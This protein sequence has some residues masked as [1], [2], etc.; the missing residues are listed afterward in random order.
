MSVP[1]NLPT[2]HRECLNLAVI[3]LDQAE[4]L[5]N[6]NGTGDAVLANSVA[7]IGQ[8]WAAVA[9]AM[10]EAERQVTYVT[11]ELESVSMELGQ[12][13][14]VK[15]DLSQFKPG[16]SVPALTP[17]GQEGWDHQHTSFCRHNWV[18]PMEPCANNC[19]QRPTDTGTAAGTQYCPAMCRIT[20]PPVPT[21]DTHQSQISQHR[22][23]FSSTGRCT[24]CRV[25]L[26]SAQTSCC[27]ARCDAAARVLGSANSVE[28]VEGLS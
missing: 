19:G 17:A 1:A 18:R 28:F 27:P 26:E 15:P 13:D 20:D 22:H 9:S 5:V 7:R 25:L 21:V 16:Q 24:N 10:L 4:T 23:D 3:A 6:R 2:T 14:S 12:F 11:G 8:G